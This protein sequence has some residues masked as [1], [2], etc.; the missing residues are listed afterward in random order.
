VKHHLKLTAKGGEELEVLI[1]QYQE[2]C[3]N[4]DDKVKP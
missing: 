3:D 1:G 4:F 2:Y